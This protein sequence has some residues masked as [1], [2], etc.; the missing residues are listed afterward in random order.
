MKI[1]HCKLL[2]ILQ[3]R[4]AEF[5]VLEITARSAADLLGIQPNSAT[6]F[7]RKLRDVNAY[8]LKQEAHEIFDG[9]VEWGESYFSG[10][11]KGKRGRGAAGQVIAFGILK[12]GGKVFTKVLNDSK[13]ETLLPLIFWKIAPDSIMYTDCYRS[14]NALDVSDFHHESITQR[15]LQE[16]RTASMAL[17][18]SGI[19]QACD[20]G[21]QRDSQGIVSTILQ[22]M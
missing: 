14:Y 22:G 13:T 10:V 18:T 17:R 2:R 20:T 19:R 12:Q 21:I 3:L 16:A 15:C 5:F 9:A 4:L 1:T 8:Y 11:R 7:Y 6:L